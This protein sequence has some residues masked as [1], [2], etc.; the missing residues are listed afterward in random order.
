MAWE[1]TVSIFNWVKLNDFPNQ[2]SAIVH[3]LLQRGRTLRTKVEATRAIFRWASA[4]QQV[5]FVCNILYCRFFVWRTNFT[6]LKRPD[7]SCWLLSSDSFWNGSKNVNESKKRNAIKIDTVLDTAIECNKRLAD[8][9]KADKGMVLRCEAD[10]R[11][12]RSRDGYEPT[13]VDLELQVPFDH[14]FSLSA[15]I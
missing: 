15:L 1:C 6:K 3:H 5:P 7:R 8:F 12:Q 4:C 11:W 13:L 9:R 2:L 10:A 14:P